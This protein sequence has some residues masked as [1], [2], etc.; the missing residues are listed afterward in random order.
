MSAPKIYDPVTSSWVS[1]TNGGNAI[2]KTI[3]T[4]KGDL[5]GFSAPG[6]PVRI[7]A[8]PG[9]GYVPFS[10]ASAAG[11]VEHRS[12]IQRMKVGTFNVPGATGNLA[13]T[14][15]GFKPSV[16]MFTSGYITLA[17]DRIGG[18]GAMDSS[19]TQWAHSDFNNASANITRSNSR[20]DA[21]IY[22]VNFAGGAQYL[23]TYVSM[24][25]NGFTVNFSVMNAD[26]RVSWVAFA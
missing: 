9:D 7:P 14:G 6:V 24:D 23:A 19:G 22:A 3:G 16:V 17:T 8:A 1:V 10:K 18:T 4:A 13:I 12:P 5:I 2:P 20:T 15:L 21:C 25:A 26:G 11:G